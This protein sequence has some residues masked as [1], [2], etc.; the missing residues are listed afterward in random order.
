MASVYQPHN[1]IWS[2]LREAPDEVRVIECDLLI[3]R[4]LI[5]K[6]WKTECRTLPG[7][8]SWSLLPAFSLILTS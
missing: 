4:L 8:V 3:I 1:L 7:A 5:L 2:S 6:R